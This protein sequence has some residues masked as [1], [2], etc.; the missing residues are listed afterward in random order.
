MEFF[1][2]RPIFLGRNFFRGIKNGA[3]LGDDDRIRNSGGTLSFFDRPN[4]NVALIRREGL[5]TRVDFESRQRGFSQAS[6]AI[7]DLVL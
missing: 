1:L 2:F 7:P 5:E 3:N 6:E 4:L